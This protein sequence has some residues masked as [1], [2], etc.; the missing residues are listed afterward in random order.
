MF[1][2][3]VDIKLLLD[4]TLT[5]DY[6]AHRLLPYDIFGSDIFENFFTHYNCSL[7]C[8]LAIFCFIL[9]VTIFNFKDLFV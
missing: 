6:T 8:N 7:H 9:F 1:Y 3:L 5:F 4:T 2:L